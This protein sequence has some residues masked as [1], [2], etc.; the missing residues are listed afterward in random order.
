MIV[1][2]SYG[3]WSINEENVSEYLNRFDFLTG[4]KYWF[5]PN[6]AEPLTGECIMCGKHLRAVF[7]PQW[8]IK[9]TALNKDFW[10]KYYYCYQTGLILDNVNIGPPGD[11]Y[12][13]V[14]G[15]CAWCSPPERMARIGRYLEALRQERLMLPQYW[16]GDNGELEYKLEQID[17]K[18][19]FL[20]DIRGT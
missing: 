13:N 3:C 8:Y 12:G 9:T 6:M 1:Q 5:E 7:Q 17:G 10:Q 15:T 16:T 4:E 18:I 20:E 19:R 11:I 14:C 2:Y